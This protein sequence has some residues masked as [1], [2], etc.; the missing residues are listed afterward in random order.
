M[1]GVGVLRPR[2]LLI[3]LNERGWSKIFETTNFTNDHELGFC[4][5]EGDEFFSPKFHKF[6]GLA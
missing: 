5:G 1:A 2:M 6:F 3:F 4:A